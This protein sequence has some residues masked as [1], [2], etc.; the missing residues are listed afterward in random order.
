MS[1]ILHHSSAQPRQAAVLVVPVTAA[2]AA[3]A[4][5]KRRIVAGYFWR[6]TCG[7]VLSFCRAAGEVSIERMMQLLQLSLSLASCQVT[8]LCGAPAGSKREPQ[9][10]VAMKKTR[11]GGRVDDWDWTTK[12][13]TISQ[14]Y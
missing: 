14:E 5:K 7:C 3:A 1:T 9:R 6:Q 2:A 10:C 12:F 13:P 11:L 8:C 4:L